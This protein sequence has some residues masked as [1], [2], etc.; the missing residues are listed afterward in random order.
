MKFRLF[1]HGDF[2]GLVSGSIV[3]RF[4]L[5]C[6]LEPSLIDFVNY[7]SHPLD[8]WNEFMF[9]SLFGVTIIKGKKIVSLRPKME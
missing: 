6:G 7:S 2:D 9:P 1:T 4:C 3:Y 8:V 5:E